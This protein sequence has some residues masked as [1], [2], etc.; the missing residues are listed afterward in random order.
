[1]LLDDGSRRGLL[2]HFADFRDRVLERIRSSNRE[3]E[4]GALETGKALHAV[5]EAA[6]AYTHRIHALR[7]HADESNAQ[8]LAAAISEQTGHVGQYSSD[9]GELIAAQSADAR[10]S[11]E[12][13]ESI[14]LAAREIQRLVNASRMLALNAQVEAAR[15]GEAGKAF[16]VVAAEMKTFAQEMAR[17]NTSISSMVNGMKLALPK[18][19]E[20]AGVMEERS[21]RFAASFE[22]SVGR[23]RQLT[24]GM[25]QAIGAVIDE[26]GATLQAVLQHSETG[27]SALQFQDPQ[28]QALLY[29]DRMAHDEQQHLSAV[30]QV[31]DD[32]LRP[33]AHNN[34]GDQGVIH[35]ESSGEVL[36]F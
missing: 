2:R 20:R 9:L 32:R 34:L 28:A 15:M 3:S 36:L 23:I 6:R 5:V 25:Q 33:S 8:S 4:R 35:S 26:G 27:L 24:A 14:A 13:L 1:M 11:L 21:H 19:A 10:Q 17:A 12:R 30:L 22:E 16:A 29:I 31:H 7:Q 18:M